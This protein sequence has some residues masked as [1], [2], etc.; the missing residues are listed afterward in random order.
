MAV[1]S[2][3]ES[4]ESIPK[5]LEGVEDVSGQQSEDGHDQD[6]FQLFVVGGSAAEVMTAWFLRVILN[7][8]MLAYIVGRNMLRP[9]MTKFTVIYLFIFACS[10]GELYLIVAH[11]SPQ[12]V[13]VSQPFTGIYDG[14][15]GG[16]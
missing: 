7:G 6:S 9:V 16:P 11:D 14:V 4:G 15:C 13:V 3:G 2:A 12:M 10:I 8:Q 1:R 5:T